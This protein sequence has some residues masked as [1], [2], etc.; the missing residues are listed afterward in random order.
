M[1][2][3]CLKVTAQG[4]MCLWMLSFNRAILCASICYGQFPL[5]VR[6]SSYAHVYV[7]NMAQMMVKSQHVRM[8]PYEA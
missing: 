7:T 1:P 6:E 3:T 4:H 5:H 2:L 8:L